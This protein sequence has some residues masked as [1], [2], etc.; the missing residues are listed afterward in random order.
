MDPKLP[1]KK[2]SILTN[3]QSIIDATFNHAEETF[4]VYCNFPQDSEQCQRI[5]YKGA[6][7]T[8]IRLPGHVGEGPYA[9]I[10]SM[11]LA[12]DFEFPKHHLQS[13]SLQGIS[14]PV[15]EVKIDY[16]FHL[17][18]KQDQPINMRIDFTNLLYHG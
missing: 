14:N 16:N 11:L 3:N 6:E 5:W 8:I 4:H 7:D 1:R 13:R 12:K 10:V 17:I 15:Y 2:R 18:K 9:R